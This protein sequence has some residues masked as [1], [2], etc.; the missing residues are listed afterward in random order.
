MIVQLVTRYRQG[1]KDIL[2]S[3]RADRSFH[4]LEL[5]ILFVHCSRRLPSCLSYVPTPSHLGQAPSHD[6]VAQSID[7]E[8][9]LLEMWSYYERV[10][11]RTENRNGPLV[12][13]G[14]DFR[15]QIRE[16]GESGFWET[17]FSRR[18]YRLIRSDIKPDFYYS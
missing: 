17:G 8:K 2:L 13:K 5:L 10:N 3:S 6:N 14:F 7:S 16:G 1:T 9:H 11:R 15:H 18:E 4:Q 12:A